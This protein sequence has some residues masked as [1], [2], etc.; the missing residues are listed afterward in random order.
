M[1]GLR[2]AVVEGIRA[3]ANSAQNGG[4]V[5]ANGVKHLTITNSSL[6]NNSAVHQPYCA[7]LSGAG[8]GVFFRPHKQ[9]RLLLVSTNIIGNHAQRGV[10]VYFGEDDYNDGYDN[11]AHTYSQTRSQVRIESSSFVNDPEN[12]YVDWRVQS[13]YFADS[14]SDAGVWYLAALQDGYPSTV[15]LCDTTLPVINGSLGAEQSTLMVDVDGC[16]DDDNFNDD[17]YDEV[18]YYAHDDTRYAYHYND[19]DVYGDNGASSRR[20]KK[21]KGG[22]ESNF[23]IALLIF[24]GVLFVAGI[25]LCVATD[26]LRR[27]QEEDD[28]ETISCEMVTC[29]NALVCDENKPLRGIQA[30]RVAAPRAIEDA[31]EVYWGQPRRRRPADGQLV[32]KYTLAR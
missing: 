13:V 24:A 14:Y 21:E 6:R 16:R 29:E 9:S 22:A 5:Y 27:R 11:D 19:D 4:G 3:S 12:G 30:E 8:G 32:G 15:A 28:G 23:I 26:V 18:Y 20:H 25:A 31:D 1:Y 17:K 7:H 2:N 10:G